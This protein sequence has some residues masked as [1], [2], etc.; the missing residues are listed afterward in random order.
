MEDVISARGTWR[1]AWK[2]Y[3]WGEVSF[4]HQIGVYAI[5]EY[6]CNFGDNKGKVLF[7]PAIRTDKFKERNG[8]KFYWQDTSTSYD[9]LEKAIIGAIA[10]NFDGPNSRAAN[11]FS[12]MIGLE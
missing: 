5:I 10:Y 2:F 4:V 3:V 9:S 11:Y 8:G 1:G 7:H 12:K 6:V